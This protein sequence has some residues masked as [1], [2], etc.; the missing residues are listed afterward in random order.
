[1]D[2]RKARN[3]SWVKMSVDRSANPR[4]RYTR[5]GCNAKLSAKIRGLGRLSFRNTPTLDVR[6]YF[7]TT[8]I[9]RRGTRKSIGDAF[10][11]FTWGGLLFSV[12]GVSLLFMDHRC[13]SLFALPGL[14][15]IRCLSSPFFGLWGL[16]MQ[17]YGVTRA[18]L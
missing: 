12:A 4:E 16:A 11:Q 1:M 9:D 14:M 10:Q 13:T 5:I 2:R 17:P 6:R 15:F 7:Q 18:M 3:S 8:N